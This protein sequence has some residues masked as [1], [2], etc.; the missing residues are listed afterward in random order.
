MTTC[1]NIPIFA[2]RTGSPWPDKICEASGGQPKEEK[3]QQ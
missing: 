3:K 1:Q 2:Q